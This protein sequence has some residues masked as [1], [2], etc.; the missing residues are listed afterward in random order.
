MNARKEGLDFPLLGLGTWQMT[1]D[2]CR[3]AVS[4][5]LSLGYRHL[6]TAQGY[7]NE[8][9]VGAGLRDSGLSREDVWITTKVWVE[10]VPPEQT[11]RSVE[12]SLVRLRIDYLDLVLVHWPSRRPGSDHNLH[13]L[14]ILQ[15]RG[16][17]RYI[18]V[19]NFPPD[20][21]EAVLDHHSLLTNQVEYHPYLR[22]TELL[23]L[24]RRRDV[25]ITAYSPLGQGRVSEDPVLERIGRRHGKTAG[26]VCLRWLMQQPNVAVI[27]K[28]CGEQHLR[29]NFA[30]FDFELEE[31][32]MAEIFRLERGHRLL[33][34]PFAPCW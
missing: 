34:P 28:A 12:E 32:E 9:D 11:I 10:D 7:E 8:A 30:I 1:G 31:E 33:D 21:F 27:P 26:Q 13:A 17:T 23:E 6:D 2:E 20:M 5:A 22:Q 19:S 16:Q 18:G 15:N 4:R 24:A 3:R 29:E 25:M 14:R